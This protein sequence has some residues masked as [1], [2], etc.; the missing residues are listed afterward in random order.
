MTMARLP[1]YLEWH[2]RKLRV[3]VKVPMTAHAV[4]DKSKLSIR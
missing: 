3:R 4:L 2:G 1:T